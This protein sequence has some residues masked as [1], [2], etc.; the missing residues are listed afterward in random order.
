MDIDALLA[1][2]RQF[3]PQ[4]LEER[5]WGLV[6]DEEA[7]CEEVAAEVERRLPLLAQ[8]K[9]IEWV[10]ERATINRYNHLWYACC[11]ADGTVR[12]HEAWAEL[13]THLFQ[14]VMKA[15]H[16]QR[17]IAEE[18]LQE[19]LLRL[20]DKQDQ[21]R[22]PGTFMLWAATAARREAY[23]QMERA[24]KR[25]DIPESELVHPNQ[26]TDLS[27]LETFPA[28]TADPFDAPRSEEEIKR[29]FRELILACVRNVRYRVTLMRRFLEGSTVTEVAEE[30]D[31]TP[32]N[33]YLLTHRARATL[34][35]CDD[36]WKMVY[37]L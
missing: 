4:T 16:H 6:Q 13:H 21:L 20:W 15:T 25:T 2:C 37:S 11:R 31:T 34:H 10:I 19:V 14:V 1:H 9:P 30:L 12:Q 27:L 24:K 28:P 22:D 3:V 18:S 5:G 8:T 7:F 26:E 36:F 33:V 35:K 29:L 23:E 32:S 17:S